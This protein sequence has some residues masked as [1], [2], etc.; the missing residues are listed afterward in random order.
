MFDANG[1]SIPSWQ[2]IISSDKIKK[3]GVG[4]GAN[5]AYASRG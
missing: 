2:W 5:A 3:N 4:G 1:G